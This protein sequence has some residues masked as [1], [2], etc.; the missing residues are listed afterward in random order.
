MSG[1]IC[2]LILAV[3]SGV[4]VTITAIAPEG[5]L[6]AVAGLAF[7]ATFANALLG[8]FTHEE[9]RVAAALTFVTAAA[10]VTFWGISGAFWALVVGLVTH[11]VLRARRPAE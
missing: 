8:A 2:Y 7:L 11:G 9:Y 3:L 4:L 6:E 1:G 5:L 10:G